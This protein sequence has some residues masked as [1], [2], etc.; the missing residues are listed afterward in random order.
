[1]TLEIASFT[2]S[3]VH[4]ASGANSS[5]RNLCCNFV[6]YFIRK[7]ARFLARTAF[8][9]LELSVNMKSNF[10]VRDILFLLIL[11]FTR[12][13]THSS[14]DGGALLSKSIYKFSVQILILLSQFALLHCLR[15]F[16]I[17]IRLAWIWLRLSHSKHFQ[18]EYHRAKI[19]PSSWVSQ[20]TFFASPVAFFTQS[21]ISSF[22]MLYIHYKRL[23]RL[24]HY[25][26]HSYFNIQSIAHTFSLRFSRV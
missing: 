15:Q 3:N 2:Q 13:R 25:Y 12:I 7:D 26:L 24:S 5:S 10:I 23:C 1:M 18:L 21:L 16:S 14:I 22:H 4:L 11:F 9:G 8:I 6:S 17:F 20:S 19:Q